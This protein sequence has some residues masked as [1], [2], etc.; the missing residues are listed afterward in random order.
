M[1]SSSDSSASPTRTCVGC[2]STAPQN[3][4]LR[5]VLSADLVVPDLQTRLPG[6]GAYL[7]RSP[8][9]IDRAIQRRS[10]PRAL[11]ADLPL[12]YEQLLAQA[13]GFTSPQA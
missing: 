3:Q 5:V 13:S 4:L 9:C 7:H 10:L 1:T 6:R 12:N 8:A 11:R 2:R